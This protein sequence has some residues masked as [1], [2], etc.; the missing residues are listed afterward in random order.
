MYHS[1]KDDHDD[2]SHGLECAICISLFQE[3]EVGRKLP[4]CGH[5]FHVECIDMWLNSHSTCPICRSG[6][7][8]E[9]TMM[10]M[11]TD[12]SLPEMIA[13][14][15]HLEIEICP[16][17]TEIND[18][19]AASVAVGN[20]DAVSSAGFST[21]LES[22]LGESLRRMLSSSRVERKAHPSVDNVTELEV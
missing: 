7:I 8:C 6:I 9:T 16:N 5:A 11:D 2:I 18:I 1:A 15:L 21:S 17:T 3:D 10:N 14:S 20:H 13:G 12:G 4:K 22:A 19:N